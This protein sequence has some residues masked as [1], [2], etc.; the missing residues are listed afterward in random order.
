MH[1]MSCHEWRRASSEGDGPW[2]DN[3]GE[4]EEAC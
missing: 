4:Q 2:L 3:E 1:V